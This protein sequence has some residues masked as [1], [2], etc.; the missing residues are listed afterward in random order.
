MEQCQIMLEKY[1]KSY[2]FVSPHLLIITFTQG[3]GIKKL[4]KWQE[5][6]LGARVVVDGCHHSGGADG[7]VGE[8]VSI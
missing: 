3:G 7:T 4:R 2:D 5:A 6:G 1:I 8:Q